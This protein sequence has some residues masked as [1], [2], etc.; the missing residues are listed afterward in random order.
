M[1]QVILDVYIFNLFYDERP[2]RPSKRFQAN[3]LYIHISGGLENTNILALPT[4]KNVSFEGK[5]WKRSLVISCLK[6]KVE[7]EN[8]G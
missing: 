8:G 6:K 7:R 5:N 4:P 3:V 1:Y 2:F